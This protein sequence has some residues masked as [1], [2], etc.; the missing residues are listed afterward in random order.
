MAATKVMRLNYGSLL[1]TYSNYNGRPC[2]TFLNDGKFHSVGDG[3]R[4]QP[5][6]RF[7][8]VVV[9]VVVV[10]A[11]VRSSKVR[12]FVRS[13]VRSFVR[14]LMNEGTNFGTNEL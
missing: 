14:C 4:R 11:F 3:R 8:A 1:Y 7:V 10:V 13:K 12:S 2:D 9:V 5:F 6:R